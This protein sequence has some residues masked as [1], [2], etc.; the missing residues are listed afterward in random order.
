MKNN[1]LSNCQYG[2]RRNHSTLYVV[3]DSKDK[4]INAIILNKYTIN[5]YASIKSIWYCWSWQSFYINNIGV[6]LGE[7]YTFIMVLKYLSDRYQYIYI[8]SKQFF[9]L[10]LIITTGIPR[11]S[12]IRLLSIFSLYKW[13]CQKFPHAWL[14]YVCPV[15]LPYFIPNQVLL[16]LNI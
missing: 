4:I 3:T 14:C 9:R 12:I 16:T 6:L 15:I 8:L 10:L 5:I 1:V 11:G 13:Y 7:K 2:F